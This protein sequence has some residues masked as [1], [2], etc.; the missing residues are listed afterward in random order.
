[1]V[2]GD[3]F[4]YRDDKFTKMHTRNTG[5]LLYMNYNSIKVFRK[6][7]GKDNVFPLHHLN[8]PVPNTGAM[9]KVPRLIIER[10]NLFTNCHGVGNDR[11]F[12]EL[13]SML[14]SLQQNGQRLNSG[15]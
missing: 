7:R 6:Q 9:R 1:M 15:Y 5:S 14:L 13:P 4:E 12:L 11:L 8:A 10:N 3:V 2:S